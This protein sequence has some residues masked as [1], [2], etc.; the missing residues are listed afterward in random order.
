ML[1]GLPVLRLPVSGPFLL[2]CRRRLLCV[3]AVLR[4]GII[5]ENELDRFRGLL[6]GA[7]WARLLLLAT[8]LEDFFRIEICL[9]H[10]FLVVVLVVSLDPGRT[11]LVRGIEHE[12]V[13]C[14]RIATLVDLLHDC[15]DIFR[16]A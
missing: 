12:S 3:G 11:P 16:T 4:H 2:G 14:Q 9:A 15:V 10:E 7:A 13:Q 1:P 5:I 8:C 6:L